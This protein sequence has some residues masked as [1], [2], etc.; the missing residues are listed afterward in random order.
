[1]TNKEAIEI[2]SHY[3]NLG[4]GIVIEG[5]D[6]S[7]IV[8]ALSLA[9]K[10]LEERPQGEIKK[11]KPLEPD[12]N[13]QCAVENLRSAYWSNE[14]EKVAKN[15]TEAEDIIISAICHHGYAVCKQSQGE[16]IEL[17]DEVWKL[18]KKHQS[19]LATYVLEF[20]EE[21]TDLLGKYNDGGAE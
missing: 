10:V 18:Y 12:Y 4:Y 13:V 17:A 7:K 3:T 1:M 6:T 5:E 20:G 9:R 2:L 19:H 21:L 15:F 16:L 11:Y 8:Q 14:P